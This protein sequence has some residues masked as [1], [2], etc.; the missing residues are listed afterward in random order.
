MGF[1][2]ACFLNSLNNFGAFYE[3]LTLCCPNLHTTAFE[4][5]HHCYYKQNQVAENKMFKPENKM[6]I[7]TPI[8][9]KF[10]GNACKKNNFLFV[11]E[12]FFNGQP[13]CTCGIGS[14][15]SNGF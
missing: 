5:L 4:A 14:N 12:L 6:Y 7:T 3:I 2:E 15:K 9:V 11:V 1:S 13:I 10:N 8:L